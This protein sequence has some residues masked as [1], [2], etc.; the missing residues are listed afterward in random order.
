[1]ASYLTFAGGWDKETRDG[2]PFISCASKG[3]Y[4]RIYDSEA[5]KGEN[6]PVELIARNKQTGEEVP[7][8]N[9]IVIPNSNQR[10][11]KNDPSFDVKAKISD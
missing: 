3:D 9:F 10:E 11:G 4:A 7:I 5:K 1:M 6:C 2:T 8:K